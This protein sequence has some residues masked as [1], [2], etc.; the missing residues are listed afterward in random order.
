MQNKPMNSNSKGKTL[1]SG[2]FPEES[3]P[4]CYVMQDKPM[5]SKGKIPSSGWFPEE[6]NP[7][8]YVMQDSEPTTLPVVLF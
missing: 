7:Q 3:N 6:S 5:N 2:R 4:Q 1:S 8:C